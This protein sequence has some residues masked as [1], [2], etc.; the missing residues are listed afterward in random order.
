[1]KTIDIFIKSYARD[2]W[3]LHY[4]LQSIERNV[5]GYNNVVLLIPEKDK[6]LFD[7][8]LVPPRTLIHY[9]EEFG[10][11]YLFQQLCKIKAFNYCDAEYIL[12]GDSDCLFTYPID[13]QPFV[14]DG[15][16]EILYTDWS[17]VGDGEVWRKPTEDVMGE[18][19]PW[20]FMRRNTCIYHK[21]TLENL[22][23]WEPHLD[24][25]IMGAERFSEFNLIGAYSYKY[26]KEKYNF[27]NT[28]DW[29]YVPPKAEQL[30]SYANKEPTQNIEL[31][32]KE[33]IR[34]LETI[35]KTFGMPVPD[36]NKITDK[37]TFKIEV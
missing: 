3:L 5:Y 25:I 28:D 15:K 26:E 37:N 13:L 16:P 11:G 7:T 21:S 31:H 24:M 20:D 36:K 9:V 17:K 4:A 35:M 12:F 33:Y 10:N 2:F 34:V 18:P 29:E 8:R 6:E 22:N 1:M 32:L 27:I 14:T 30:W 23:K 19:V